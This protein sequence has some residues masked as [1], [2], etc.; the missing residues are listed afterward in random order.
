MTY[1]SSGVDI[2]AGDHLVQRIKSVA[3]STSRHG[4]DPDLG[5]F[6]GT[7]DLRSCGYTDPLLVASTDGVGTKLQV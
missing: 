5:Q 2:A 6:A 1:A 7:F 3:K 4:C